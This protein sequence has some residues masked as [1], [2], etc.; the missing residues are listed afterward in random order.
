MLR[1]F[2]AIPLPDDSREC[3]LTVQ[4][5]S[6]PGM[7]LIGRQEL[8][9]TLHFLGELT[10]ASKEAVQRTLAKVK[11]NAFTITIKGLGVFPTEGQPRVLWSGV[12]RSPPLFALH[13]ALGAA[14]ID[15]IGFQ[16]EERS[17]SP[18]V[19]LARLNTPALPGAIERYL[20]ENKGFQVP[21]ILLKHFALYSSIL[22]NDSPLYREEAVFD[23]L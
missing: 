6:I 7:R 9:L 4:P 8:H 12:E 17:Y 13:H 1:Y 3:L 10:P 21:S 11:V 16:L 15:A 23:L 2:V 14:L 19:T 18:H 20:E 22:A 5:H